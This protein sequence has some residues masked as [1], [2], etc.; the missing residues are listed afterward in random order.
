MWCWGKCTT[1]FFSHPSFPLLCAPDVVYW[2]LIGRIVFTLLG[3]M[4]FRAK[5]H[6][7]LWLLFF[8]FIAWLIS[9]ESIIISPTPFICFVFNV[10]II[11]S[12]QTLPIVKSGF[13]M[14]IPISCSIS[15]IFLETSLPGPPDLPQPAVVVCW[16]VTQPKMFLYY[17]PGISFSSYLC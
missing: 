16:P 5:P 8:F 3:L 17:R 6:C 11:N 10:V 4:F 9:L 7:I 14:F 12:P 15:L 13:H 1:S 2:I